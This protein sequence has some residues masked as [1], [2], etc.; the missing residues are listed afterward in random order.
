VDD[1][2]K[3]EPGL[4]VVWS[5]DVPCLLPFRIPTRGLVVGRELFGPGGTDDRISRRHARIGTSGTGGAFI[6]TDLGS[7]NGTYAGGQALVDRE[8]TVTS[9][10]VIR[11]GRTVSVLVPDITGYEG[12]DVRIE[13]AMVW[14]PATAPVLAIAAAAAR[15]RQNL[16]VVGEPGV[17]KRAIADAY[18]AHR[19]GPHVTLDGAAAALPKTLPADTITL[20]LDQAHALPA[21][22]QLALRALLEARA[23]L[24][25]ITLA[26]GELDRLIDFDTA[27]GQ[28]L[29]GRVVRL[30]P[31]RE[32]AGELAHLV[33]STV[34]EV[35]PK[36]GI[37][38]TLIEAC[39]L[40]PWPGN[41]RELRSEITRA[42]HLVA[43][44]GKPMV[45]G[46]DLEPEA[47]H[48]LT[49]APT[50]NHT[51]QP[52]LAGGGE[53]RRRRASTKTGV[54]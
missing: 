18:V 21:A 13:G 38:S 32:R 30:A 6:V 29:S 11:T 14:G 39:L 35:E 17:G 10:C 43:G 53:R 34:R 3:P 8:I 44:A 46:E 50:I 26:M 52:T 51:A 41:V 47:G 40:R 19:D 16:V 54:D 31:L 49:G 25:V 4:L 15:E 1:V 36:L 7:R 23:E 37:H 42:A 22:A 9:P 2:K 24:G 12:Q 5:G 48:L 33:A 28:K 20:V 45:R 27:L